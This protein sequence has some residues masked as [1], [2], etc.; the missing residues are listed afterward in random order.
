[1]TALADRVIPA[2]VLEPPGL[3]PNG[4]HGPG[5]RVLLAHGDWIP[6]SLR[7]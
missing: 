5:I 1:M 6:E 3:L 2:D 4:T 7:T